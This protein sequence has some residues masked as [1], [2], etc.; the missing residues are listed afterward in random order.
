MA[1]K[2]SAASQEKKGGPQEAL[3]SVSFGSA[4]A[5]EEKLN[6]LFQRNLSGLSEVTRSRRLNR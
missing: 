6:A 2:E 3:A 1:G 4:G 5:G